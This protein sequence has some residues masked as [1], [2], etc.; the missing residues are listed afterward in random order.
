[1]HL[2]APCLQV[3]WRLVAGGEFVPVGRLTVGGPNGGQNVTCVAGMLCAFS[4]DGRFPGREHEVTVAHT[5]CGSLEYD[6]N[7]T[8]GD[9]ATVLPTPAT[10]ETT[11][12]L[13][14]GDKSP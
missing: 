9:W 4:L 13:K 5:T 7:T 12:R 8:Q 6:G 1:M 10:R 3:W 2:A 14:V 11:A